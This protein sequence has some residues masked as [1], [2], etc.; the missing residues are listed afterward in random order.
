MRPMTTLSFAGSGDRVIAMEPF[1]PCYFPS[2]SKLFPLF[3]SCYFRQI[4]K[5]I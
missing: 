2:Y 1:R 4:S 3:F 5:I